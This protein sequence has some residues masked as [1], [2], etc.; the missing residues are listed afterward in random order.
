MKLY[1]TT[2][3]E[4]ASKGQ[5]GNNRLDTIITDSDKNQ[6]VRILIQINDDNTATIKYWDNTMNGDGF[7]SQI[8]IK[9]EKKKGDLCRVCGKPG[10]YAGAC[11]IAHK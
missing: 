10:K 11:P 6:V 4:R 8:K 5:G 1:A 9:G 7:T 3:S 2:T